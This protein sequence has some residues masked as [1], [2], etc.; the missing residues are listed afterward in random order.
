M[1]QA[2]YIIFALLLF[3][4]F[5]FNLQRWTFN[6]EIDVMPTELIATGLAT[7]HLHEIGTMDFGDL[8]SMHRPDDPDPSHCTNEPIV[9]TWHRCKA[10]LLQ[11]ASTPTP[12]RSTRYA[13]PLPWF[14]PQKLH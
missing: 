7:E 1:K 4:F 2:L 12:R 11:N 8:S 10:S 13:V 9:D 3:S 14:S 6:S 5:A